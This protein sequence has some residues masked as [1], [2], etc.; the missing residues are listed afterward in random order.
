[1][2]LL[3]FPWSVFVPVALVAGWKKVWPARTEKQRAAVFLACG[4]VF[5][6]SF[7]SAS[8]SKL[9]TYITPILP[10][11]AL[12]IGAYFDRAIGYKSA[13][14]PLAL[15]ATFLALLLCSG[16]VAALLVGP[17]NLQ[18]FGVS[19]GWALFLGALLLAWALALLFA[20]W[21]APVRAIPLVVASGFTVVFTGAILLMCA[22]APVLTTRPLL[23]RLGPGLGKN[24]QIATYGFVQS[25]SFYAQ[26]RVHVEGAPDELAAGINNFRPL[27]SGVGSSTAPPNCAA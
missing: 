23:V 20:S 19:G 18:P 21:R 15:S 22:L 17:K 10:L 11:L 9:V 27:K 8:D 5:I 6:V 25:A 1:M 12:L 13:R 3:F 14:W 24:T 7:F 26:R 4:C 16:G 2:P